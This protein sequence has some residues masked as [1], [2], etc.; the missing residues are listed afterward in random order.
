MPSP[1]MLGEESDVFIMGREA[2]QMESE[3]RKYMTECS[4]EREAFKLWGDMKY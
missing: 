3:Q 1:Q 4:H 2:E